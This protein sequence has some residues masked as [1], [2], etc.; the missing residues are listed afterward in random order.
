[1]GHCPQQ[2][3]RTSDILKP[4]SNEMIDTFVCQEEKLELVKLLECVPIPVKES[5]EEPAA[6]IN[7]LLQAYIISQLKLDT[8]AC[9]D[10]C[11]MVE[12][13]MWGSMT[14]LC[15]FK[16]VP[17]EVVRKAEGK[18]FPWYQYFDLSLL[19]IGELIGIQNAG[20]LVHGLVHSFPKLQLQAQVQ[21]I[22]RSLIKIDLPIIPD[23]WWDEKIHGGADTFII[24]VEDVNREIIL[25]HNNFLLLQRYSRSLSPS[26]P[27]ISSSQQG[28]RSP[29]LFHYR[30]LQQDPNT[31]L[32][33]SVYLGAP[34]GSSKTIC[35]EFALLRLW[36]KHEQ[37][38]A[39]CIEPFQ[40]M[41][42]KEIVSLTV[43]T[44]EKCSKDW[45]SHCQQGP[46]SEIGPT[47]EVII[48]HTQYVSAQTEIKT[49]IIA[50]G[51]SL[52]NARDLGEWIGAPSHAI[53]NF[54][55]LKCATPQ[56]GY[57]PPIVLYP[58]FSF[59]HDRH[60]HLLDHLSEMVKTT[61]NNLVNSKYIA[62]EDEMDVSTLN[63]DMIA[64]YYNILYATVKIYTLSLKEHTKLH[65]LL[66]CQVPIC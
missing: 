41:G 18:Q 26:S 38:C 27:T 4:T 13:R 29:I 14:P 20:R 37:R 46:A 35:A 21:P 56:H 22:T 42:G 7:V 32:P 48:L 64:A 19:E 3:G 15:Q 28:V 59:A 53:F 57:P 50:C 16:G 23:F 61:L 12:K 51:V 39:I 5:V 49:C 63:L 65:G 30:H 44:K 66:I 54:V 6:K 47:Y 43:E 60:E 40:E 25:F 62:I 9:L 58:S 31:S 11:K 17:V 2:G 55:F 8:K 10:L 34:T 24:L 45:S 1:M 36:S 33:G 52:A